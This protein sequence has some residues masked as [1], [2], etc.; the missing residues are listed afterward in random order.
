M[1]KE[2]LN[3]EILRF[4]LVGGMAVFIDAL[5]YYL[6]DALT[7]LEPANSKRLSFLIGSAWAFIMN[8][9][10]TFEQRQLHAHEPVLF[11]LVYLLGF[12]LNSII[13]DTVLELL[14]NKAIAFVLA[15][16]VSTCTN[17]MGQKWIVFRKK[18]RAYERE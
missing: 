15:T 3:K 4:I 16:G 2:K 5:S 12:L 17:F 13:H 10:Y 6:L 18:G 14:Q 7:Q 11:A 1:I 9:F 8:K